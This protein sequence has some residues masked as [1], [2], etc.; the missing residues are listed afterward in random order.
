MR[1][2]RG[3]SAHQNTL[4]PSKRMQLRAGRIHAPSRRELL[5]ANNCKKPDT[6]VPIN[7]RVEKLYKLKLNLSLLRMQ[8]VL[9]TLNFRQAYRL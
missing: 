1:P 4:R 2:K 8:R 6:C 9:C 5:K 3:V 7:R